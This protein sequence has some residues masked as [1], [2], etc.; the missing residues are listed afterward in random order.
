[1]KQ[2][3]FIRFRQ[4]LAELRSTK[5]L[6]GTALLSA[7]NIVLNQFTIMVSQLLEIGFAFLATACCAYLYGPWLAGLAGLVTDTIGYFLRPN[8]PYFPFFAINELLLG[9]IFGCFFYKKPVSLKR[10][11]LACLTVVLV[12]NLFLTPVWLNLMYGNASLISGLRLV[13]NVLKLPLDTFLLYTVL[14]ALQARRS[15]LRL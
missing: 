13:K 10:T 7:I 12:I 14:K 6:A 5:S 11:F 3:V 1:M 2:T 8:G 9:F 15:Q 4:A